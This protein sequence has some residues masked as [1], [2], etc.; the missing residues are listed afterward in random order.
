MSA[1][2]CFNHYFCSVTAD[3]DYQ[4]ALQELDEALADQDRTLFSDA[5]TELT[6]VMEKMANFVGESAPEKTS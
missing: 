3:D 1:L 4:N 6:D 5:M 2:R